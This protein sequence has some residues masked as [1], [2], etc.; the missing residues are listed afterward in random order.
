MT[1]QKLRL[2]KI[3]KLRQLIVTGLIDH[4]SERVRDPHTKIPST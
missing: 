4:I 1:R 2:I 3:G